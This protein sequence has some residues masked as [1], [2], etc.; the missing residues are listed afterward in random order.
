[1]ENYFYKK[2]VDWSVLNL[3]INIPVTI[4][5]EIYNLIGEKL[6]KGDK[7]KISIVYNDK[8]YIVLLVNQSFDE[9]KYPNHKNLLQIRYTPN[10]E[11]SQMLKC[12]FKISYDYL[13][14]QKQNLQ[15]RKQIKIPDELKEYIALYQ[16]QTENVFRLETITASEFVESIS[17]TSK[18]DE[19]I[20]ERDFGKKDTTS[21]IVH[22]EKL[23]KVR[24]LDY[25]IIYSLKKVY[26]YRCQICGKSF[27]EKYD[28]NVCEGHHIEYFSKSLNNDFSNIIILC[29]NHHSVIH[30]SE[31]TF[32]RKKLQFE[33]KNGYAEKV[34]INQHL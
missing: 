29:P 2:Q 15:S 19:L 18:L 5:Q 3:G 9:R 32:N 33:Y 20:L 28:V 25:S 16:T 17:I 31:P 26:S 12:I 34:N 8:I 7:S 22:K 23:V 10:S 21:S 13:L 24:Q 30:S 1:M 27:F 6:S 4:Q 11:F 14:I